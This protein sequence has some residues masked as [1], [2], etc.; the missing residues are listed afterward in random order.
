M[1]RAVDVTD[2]IEC[3]IELDIASDING[4]PDL[5]EHSKKQQQKDHF[6][7]PAGMPE[8]A[9]CR[10]LYAVFDGHGGSHCS[11]TAATHIC[12]DVMPPW[13]RYTGYLWTCI[14]TPVQRSSQ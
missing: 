10:S 4:M 3:H 8:P 6:L 2:D 13:R 7:K 9:I 5:H 14:C 11:C 12:D 1:R